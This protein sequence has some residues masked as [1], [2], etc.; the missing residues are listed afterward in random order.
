M[1]STLNESVRY[2]SADGSRFDR[3]RSM[4]IS[5][6]LTVNSGLAIPIFRGI[7]RLRATVA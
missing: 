7:L 1:S 5:L 6:W 2:Q 4:S 3:V